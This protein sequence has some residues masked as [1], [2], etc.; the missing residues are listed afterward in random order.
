MTADR[1][2]T[3][4]PRGGLFLPACLVVLAAVSA[5]LG[6]SFYFRGEGGDYNLHRIMAP[7]ARMNA[8]WPPEARRALAFHRLERWLPA[9]AVL[10]L[11]GWALASRRLAR[12][13]GMRREV[14]LAGTA[15][16]FSPLIALLLIPAHYFVGLPL[17]IAPLFIMIL[18]VGLC[19][20]IA[21]HVLRPRFEG[22]LARVVCSVWGVWVLAAAYGAAFSVL[23]CLKY[24]ALELGYPDSGSFAETVF[25]LSEGRAPIS[26]FQPGDTVFSVHWTLIL[27]PISYLYRLWP[28][29]EMLLVLQSVG[30]GVGGV[31]VYLLA[32]TVLKDRFAAWAFAVAYFLAATTAYVNLP[33]S[34]GFRPLTLLVPAML[35]AMVFLERGRLLWYFFFVLLALLCKEEAAPALVMLGLFVAVRHRKWATAAA[36]IVLAIGWFVLATKSMK[37]LQPID[38]AAFT[39][40]LSQFGLT[41]TEVIRNVLR[42]PLGWLAT[43]FDEPVKVFFLLHLLVP[44]L[45]LPIFSPSALLV[46]MAN[47]A[48]LTMAGWYGK[49]VILIGAQASVLPGI[50][51]AAVFGLKNLADRDTWL[52]RRLRVVRRLGDRERVMRAAACGLIAAAALTH[53]FFFL[54]TVPWKKNFVVTE[55][56]RTVR[57]LRQMILRDRSLCASYRLASHFTDQRDL[58]VARDVP[59]RHGVTHHTLLEC[60]YVLLDLYD[61]WVGLPILCRYRNEILRSGRYAPIFAHDGFLIFQRGERGLDLRARYVLRQPRQPQHR[62][63]ETFAGFA[64]L[65]GYDA[66]PTDAGLQLTLYW[67]SERKVDKDYA[68]QLTLRA[69]KDGQPTRI[70]WRY[71]PCDGILPTWQWKPGDV[72]VDGV[73]IPG[74]KPPADPSRFVVAVALEE[75]REPTY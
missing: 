20:A 64:T 17:T 31:A 45:L 43:V 55:R 13:E 32:K 74:H 36:T 46:G 23:M 35:W 67:R 73:I 42:D 7:E 12:R 21:G 29:H 11:G 1:P 30:L 72:M 28:A 38:Q 47:F 5:A 3:P 34:Y 9:C 4:R 18:S 71:A 65:V 39:T 14:A 24:W 52:L 62:Y 48:I 8:Y 56:D 2:I 22:R 59:G 66:K 6:F 60:D 68:V 54:R 63:G 50:Y 10:V 26:H 51:L 19:T 75:V 37:A 53:Y 61:D 70:G 33:T 16:I 25:H 15:R 57:K 27:V 41:P 40:H 58:Y 69:L 49:Y 44:L